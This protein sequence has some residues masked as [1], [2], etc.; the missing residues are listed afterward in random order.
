MTMIVE[1]QAKTK[2]QSAWKGHLSALQMTDLD[3]QKHPRSYLC[4][5]M[6]KFKLG[7]GRSFVSQLRVI[8]GKALGESNIIIS[9]YSVKFVPFTH[10]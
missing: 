3:Q 2:P 1:L 9:R 4:K 8:L 10:F 5:F 7:D 6:D